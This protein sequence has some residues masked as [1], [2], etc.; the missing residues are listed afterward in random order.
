MGS[1]DQ[2]HNADVIN[3]YSSSSI[4]APS[5]TLLNPS[6]GSGSNASLTLDNEFLVAQMQRML[7][8]ECH[9]EKYPV[10]II[11]N[12]YD[13]DDPALADENFL[14]DLQVLLI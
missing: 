13:P 5:E 2:Q 6:F 10:V 4:V 11:R 12:V 9:A 8:T 14:I 1:E 7:P 3:D